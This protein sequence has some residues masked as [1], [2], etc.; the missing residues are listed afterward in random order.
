MASATFSI[1]LPHTVPIPKHYTQRLTD[2]H[3]LAL[4]SFSPS[5]RRHFCLKSKGSSSTTYIS[6]PGADVII[7]ENDPEF[8]DSESESESQ[9]STNLIS[10]GLIWSLVARHKLRLAASGDISKYLQE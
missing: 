5:R 6:G 1:T 9:Q 3:R 2:H 10:W 4:R 8:Q 7:S